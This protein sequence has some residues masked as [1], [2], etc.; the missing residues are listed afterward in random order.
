MSIPRA[1]HLKHQRLSRL[2]KAGNAFRAFINGEA[3]RLAAPARVL[4]DRLKDLG[5]LYPGQLAAATDLA[6]AGPPRLTGNPNLTFAAKTA[7]T[8]GNVGF[9]LRLSGVSL[10]VGAN[11]TG[12][13]ATFAATSDTAGTIT[14]SAGDWTAGEAVVVG[15]RLRVQGS[16]ANDMIVTVTEVTSATVLTVSTPR[17]FVP[18]VKVC[19]FAMVNKVSRASGSFVTDGWLVGHVFDV[20]GASALNN[21]QRFTVAAVQAGYLLVTPDLPQVDGTVA[22]NGVLTVRNHVT[23][24][25][26]SFVTDGFVDGEVVKIGGTTANAGKFVRVKTV[27]ATTLLLETA[28]TDLVAFEAPAGSR[29]IE[30]RGTITRA[31]GSWA[32]DGFAVGKRFRV[33]GSTSNDLEL[34]VLRAVSATVIE[35][36]TGQLTAEGPAADIAAYVLDTRAR[37]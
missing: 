18:Q 2:R 22:S 19:D 13:T 3:S 1:K 26:G 12:I 25:S 30:G 37:D 7:V 34:Q 27:A 17:R 32:D 36:P 29:T 31:T 6:A 23:R 21:A 15:A 35:V 9:G 16:G 11:L 4:R 14:R 28:D 24:A 10:G 33:V 5:P 8:P 20:A